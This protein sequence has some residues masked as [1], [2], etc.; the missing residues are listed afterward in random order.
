MNIIFCEECGSRNIIAEDVLQN[1]EK[2]AIPCQVCNFL[3]SAEHLI[4]YRK[5]GKLIDTSTYKLLVVDDDKAHLTLLQAVLEKEY[6]VYIATSG[7][8]GVEKATS[9]I[10]D[11]ILLDV[12]MPDMDGYEVCSNLKNDK[13]TRHIPIIFI[14]AKTKDDDEYK[15]LSIGAVDYIVKP[16]NIKILNA[17]I[18]SHLKFRTVRNELQ[19]KIEKQEN[20][21][22]VLKEEIENDERYMLETD[23]STTRNDHTTRKVDL[24]RQH[25]IEI[26]NTLNSYVSIQDVNGRILWTNR[27]MMKAFDVIFFKLQGKK[28]YH[29]YWERTTPCEGC[30]C[31]DTNLAS[32]ITQMEKFNTKLDQTLLQTRLALYDDKNNVVAVA[33]TAQPLQSGG[34]GKTIDTISLP[35][36]NGDFSAMPIGKFNEAIST[37][38]IS[39]ETIYNMY[40]NDKK[41]A[42]LNQ[43]INDAS[44]TLRTLVN[45]LNGQTSNKKM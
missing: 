5:T 38:L 33:C 23:I 35:A 24:E 7:Q 14:T 27:S 36:I 17:K 30:I 2:H 19:Q 15:G 10:P 11:L 28:C 41:L 9:V 22:K 4:D 1:I 6:S 25:L 16:F 44:N 26:V 13:R 20:Y 8:E 21:I 3:I 29:S 45:E 31:N 18:A 42:R 40:K 43:Y 34:N 32:P 37:L 39:S 12:S